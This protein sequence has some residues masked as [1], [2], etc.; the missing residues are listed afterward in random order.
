MITLQSMF[1]K[2]NGIASGGN[3]GLHTTAKPPPIVS[4]TCLILLSFVFKE[5]IVGVREASFIRYLRVKVSLT[6]NGLSKRYAFSFG[7][8]YPC[9][10]KAVFLDKNG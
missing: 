10:G 2:V 7:T 5:I 4:T 9:N 1:T 3:I 8:G 6:F